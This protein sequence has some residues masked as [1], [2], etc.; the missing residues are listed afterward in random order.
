MRNRLTIATAALLLASASLV[1]AQP[2]TA[3]KN[4]TPEPTPTSPWTGAVDFGF[5]GTNSDGDEARLE[6]YRDLRSGLS[7]DIVVGKQS[8][9]SRMTLTARNIGYRDQRYSAS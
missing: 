2:A 7:S 6:R 1:A 8:D 4:A 3:T 5:R 9:Q